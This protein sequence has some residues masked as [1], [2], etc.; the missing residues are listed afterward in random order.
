MPRDVLLDDDD[1]DVDNINRTTGKTTI[2]TFRIPHY[3]LLEQ[4]IVCIVPTRNID[5]LL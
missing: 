1:D 5:I 4:H 3:P 2:H